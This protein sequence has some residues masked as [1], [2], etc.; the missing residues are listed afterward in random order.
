[1]LK[2]KTIIQLELHSIHWDC[3][4]LIEQ[5]KTKKTDKSHQ[6]LIQKHR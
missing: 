2:N 4:G 6:I 1:M 5:L 3:A